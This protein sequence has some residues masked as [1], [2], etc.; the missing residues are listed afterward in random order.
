MNH[1]KKIMTAAVLTMA[2]GLTACSVAGESQ[3]GPVTD[4]D[5]TTG[6]AS[7]SLRDQAR[8]LGARARST[9]EEALGLTSDF[10]SGLADGAVDEEAFKAG[11][12]N[13]RA[14]LQDMAASADTEEA[15][16]RINAIT[17]D[18]EAKVNEI[19]EQISSNESLMEIKSAIEDFWAQARDRLAEL[20]E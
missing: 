2:L 4:A 18:L 16:Q 8:A 7:T 1:F 15:R 5:R 6:A 19:L 14:K 12:E 3:A 17:A 13:L 9:A 10:L 11:W 20:M